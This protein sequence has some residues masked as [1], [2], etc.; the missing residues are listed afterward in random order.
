MKDIKEY[1][2]PNPDCLQYGLRGAGNLVKAGKYTIKG[3]GEKRQMLKCVVCSMRFSETQS[4]IFAGCHYDDQTIQRIIISAAEGESVR[5]TARKLG[6]SKDRV[7]LIV[8]KA[9][10]YADTV[11]S[12]LL[13]SLFMKEDQSDELWTFIH[14]KK[15]YRKR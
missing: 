4:G 9:R 15:T 6:L 13:R 3:S 14:N 5:V 2:C 7:N 1:F 12:N 11:L 8:R 10:T